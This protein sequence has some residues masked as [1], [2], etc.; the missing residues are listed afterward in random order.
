MQVYKLFFQVLRKQKGQ[1]IMYL[2]IFLSVTLAA[3]S[4]GEKTGESTFS[5][6]TYKFAVM[7]ADNSEI[8]RALIT[9]LE[10]GNEKVHI[11]DKKEV[12]QDEIYNRSISCVLRIPSGFFESY[13]S[14]SENKKMEVIGVPGT[15]YKESFEQMITQYMILVRGYIGGGFSVKEALAKAGKAD[16]K[17]VD[18]NVLET[19]GKTTH[20]YVYYF[21]AYVPYILLCL[22]IVGISPVLVVL[23][24]PQIRERIQCSSYSFAKTNRETIL[25][26]LSAGLLFGILYLV[27]A[28]IGA[29]E[30]VFTVQGGLHCLNLLAFL[31]VAL[32]IVFL[33]GQVMKKAETVSMVSNVIALGMS[34]LS[35]V[36][37]PIE[38][39]GDG[40]I[41]VAH[42]LPAYWYIMGARLID[43]G[44]YQSSPDLLWRYM[45]IEVLFAACFVCLGLA[46]ARAKRQTKQTA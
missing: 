24:K 18:V 33:I 31:M 2:V 39:L 1:I 36:F 45:G 21:F 28:V 44:N 15:I 9:Y 16:E 12:I 35:G 23:H 41:K 4:Q 8:S 6:T 38:F 46:L 5:P 22:C 25:G 40:I 32:G 26:T 20:S 7:D 29:R 27:C 13:L 43:S 34:F 17:T 30:R 10:Q 19:G 3:A 14:G 42:F 11:E 37:V